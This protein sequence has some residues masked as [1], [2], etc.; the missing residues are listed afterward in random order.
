[1]TGRWP[2]AAKV[3][4]EVVCKQMQSYA[5]TPET[6]NILGRGPRPNP[7]WA[8]LNC[9]TNTDPNLLP[10]SSRAAVLLSTA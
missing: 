5:V 3:V 4:P 2:Q 6:N 8:R 1:M 9:L 10:F 7:G